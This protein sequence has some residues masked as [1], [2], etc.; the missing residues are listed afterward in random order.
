MAKHIAIIGGGLAGCLTALEFADRGHGVV[1]FEREES[2]L[3]RASAANEGKV[4]LGYVY[5]AD[6]SFDTAYRLIKDALLF[7]PVLQRWMTTKE[8]EN[9]LYDPFAYAIPSE[10]SL[11]SDYILAHFGKVDDVIAELTTAGSA[12]YLGQTE[13][14][15]FVVDG[16]RTTDEIVWTQT[17]EAG[18]WPQLMADRV[19]HAIKHHPHITLHMATPVARVTGLTKGWRVELESGAQDGPFDVV[20]NAAWAE[21]RLIDQRSGYTDTYQ[22][23]TRFKFGAVLK[24]ASQHLQGTIPQNTTLTSGSF[25]DLV[26]SASIDQLYCSWYPVGMCYSSDGTFALQRPDLSDRKEELARATWKGYASID[27]S[28]KCLETAVG[29]L[30]VELKGDFIMAKGKS[31]IDDPKSQLHERRDHGPIELEKGYWT[32][33]TGKYTSSPR[34]AIE[35]VAAALS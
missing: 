19:D 11:S 26:Y 29:P 32:I 2:L 15:P 14:M 31:D 34:C 23:F 3:P 4:H 9:C 25:G 30:D 20:V 27:P 8:F 33:E 28:I 13:Q 17:R 22:W 16:S 10:S 21:R 35:C 12:P 24:N 5:A 18:V 6:K 1:L 7:R